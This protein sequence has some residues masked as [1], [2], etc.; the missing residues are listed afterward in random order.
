MHELKTV[1][2]RIGLQHSSQRSSIAESLERAFE[3]FE[4]MQ[5]NKALELKSLGVMDGI[6]LNSRGRAAKPLP[7]R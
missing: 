4:T 3:R 2:V 6:R 7:R 1:G 5:I